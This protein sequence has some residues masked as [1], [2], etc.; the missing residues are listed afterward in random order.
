LKLQDAAIEVL[1]ARG[2]PVVTEYELFR[3]IR[4]LHFAGEFDGK[5][6]RLTKHAP[7]RTRYRNIV[8]KLLADRYLRPDPDFYPES[9]DE[10]RRHDRSYS[11][12]FVFRVSDVPDGTAEDISA[13]LDPFCYISHL[14]AMQRYSLTNRIPE[15]LNLSTPK[16]WNIHRDQKLAIDYAVVREGEYIAPLKQL[17]WPDSLRKRLVSLHKTVR[18]PVVK[19]IRG[20]FS[21]IAAVGEV[22]VQMLDRPEL[23]GG[24]SHVIEVWDQSAETYL[25]D[26]I[27]AVDSAEESII[28]VRAGYLLEERLGLL[29]SRV[30][31]WADFAQRGGSR[32]LDPSA[33]YVSNFS[34]KW[35]LSLNV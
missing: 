23:C 14:S 31:D 1:R 24:M 20:G 30:S 35:M 18:S 12:A 5:K 11:Y 26:I 10:W 25:D 27:R 3:I 28:K 7:D 13:L 2:T 4:G 29:D 17:T 21:R 19:Q 8:A 16:K 32:K 6:L 22:F 33:E 15:A 9:D 34:K